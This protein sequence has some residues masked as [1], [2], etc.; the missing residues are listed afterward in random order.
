LAYKE[1]VPVSQT[2]IGH[3]LK[4]PFKWDKVTVFSAL[5]FFSANNTPGSP[6]SQAEAVSNM[7][8]FSQ[9]YS[10][11]KIDHTLCRIAHC[12][13]KVSAS[14]RMFFILLK[15]VGKFTFG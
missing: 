3:L 6:G 10:I 8:S 7:D 9:R 1:R 15:K 11:T 4:L 5:G 14:Q 2:N 12:R 13:Y